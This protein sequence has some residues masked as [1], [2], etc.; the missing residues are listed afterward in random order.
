M[1][2]FFF[3]K[4]FYDGWDNLVSFLV[5]N[6]IVDGIVFTVVAIMFAGREHLAVWIVCAALLF[7]LCS[8]AVLAWSESAVK[9]AEGFPASLTD[10]FSAIPSCIVDGL[11]YAAALF[12]L[13]AATGFGGAYY[14][15]KDATIIGLMAGFA[16][17]WVALS[18]FSALLWYPALRALMHNPVGKSV[19]KGFIIL[20]DN[21]LQ[22][23]TVA[24]YN[25]FLIL[26]SVVML[27]VAP[28]MAGL[29]LSRVNALRLILKKY[30][31]LSG[32]DKAG[33]PV[34]SPER[35]K[36]PWNAILKNDIENV[37]PRPFR[38]FIFPWK[39]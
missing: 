20:T 26:V 3:R 24:L 9:I 33:I 32:L 18:I 29:A 4:N 31:Y 5:P 7:C 13:T 30:D 35:R 11:K 15:R 38:A 1:L 36:I 25:L 28:G 23:L 10:F 39:E 27:G 17:C 2:N 37:P 16:F 8:I 14:F 19:R 12:V 22:S 21:V 6:F 34:N